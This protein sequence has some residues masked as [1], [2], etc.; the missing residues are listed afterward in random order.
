MSD[1]EIRT[2][3]GEAFLA[4]QE[5]MRNRAAVRAGAFIPLQDPELVRLGAE[6]ANQILDLPIAALDDAI[7]KL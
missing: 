5:R 4:G 2:L 6:V 3:V 1:E 7:S